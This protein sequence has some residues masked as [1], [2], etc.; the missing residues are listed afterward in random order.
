MIKVAICDGYVR[1]LL[2]EL[3]ASKSLKKQEPFLQ[4]FF[5]RSL[6]HNSRIAGDCIEEGHLFNIAQGYERRGIESTLSDFNKLVFSVMTFLLKFLTGSMM[7]RT[8]KKIPHRFIPWNPD[9]HPLS[10]KI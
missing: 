1:K 8:S 6:L 2:R 5:D 10:C 4:I 3:G 7:P 9:A